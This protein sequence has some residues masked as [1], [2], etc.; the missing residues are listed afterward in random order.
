LA[1]ELNLEEE[2][3]LLKKEIENGTYTISNSIAFVADKPVKCE[4]LA[5]NHKSIIIVFQMLTLFNLFKV[6]K[7]KIRIW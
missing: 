4:I 1:F 2:L 5:S 6:V 7:N 3:I